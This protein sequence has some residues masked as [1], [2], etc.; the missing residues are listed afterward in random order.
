MFTTVV[1]SS[2]EL[3]AFRHVMASPNPN[4]FRRVVLSS[5]ESRP[6]KFAEA[7]VSLSCVH[8]M[9]ATL[10]EDGFRKSKIP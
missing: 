1:K 9:P 8:E 6:K 10:D 4:G 2:C 5:L 3:D 7:T